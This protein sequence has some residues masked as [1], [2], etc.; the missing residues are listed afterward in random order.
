MNRRNFLGMM[1]GGI[2]ASAAV[3]TWPFRVYSFPKEVLWPPSEKQALFINNDGVYRIFGGSRNG[4]KTISQEIDIAE[5]K[6]IF[7]GP[8]HWQ[9]RGGV[10]YSVLQPDGSVV[11]A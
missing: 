10:R 1:V 4:W 9:D 8:F 5:A 2:A 3:R 6:R 7:P 11:D